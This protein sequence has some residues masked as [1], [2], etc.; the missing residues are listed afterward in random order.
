MILAVL[1][2]TVSPAALRDA[3]RQVNPLLWAAF[4][5]AAVMA[6]LA[7]DTLA[8]WAIYRR[9]LP[10]VPLRLGETFLMRGATYLLSVLHYGAGQ[11]AMA[12]FLNT[13]YGVP[14]PRAA[15][16][17]ILT[18][19]TNAIT[20]AACALLGIGLG[21]APA[22]RAL[23][24]VVLL[25]AGGLPVYLGIIALRPGFLLRMTF[26]R[27]LFDAGVRGHLVISAARMPHVLVMVT[28]HWLA[29][30]LFNIDVPF[31][32]AIA[33]LPLVFIVAVLPLSP[34][35]LGTAQATAVAL[36]A[37]FASATAIAAASAGTDPAA[38]QRAA[39]LVYSL[40]YHF[41]NLIGQALVGAV[42]LRLQS[43]KDKVK[44]G[45]GRLQ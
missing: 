45:D 31:D 23:L 30:R 9:S 10:D 29:M 21:G 24:A 1:F 37:P 5:L 19:G 41:S 17:V 40:A 38:A 26:L 44:A 3:A 2:R 28:A 43:Q 18:M 14:V 42:F 7:A 32:Q 27:P 39:V 34:S 25:I 11:G 36:F 12:Y 6:T 22:S 13:R 16:A 8:T 15:G 4:V 35:G 20:V 33:L